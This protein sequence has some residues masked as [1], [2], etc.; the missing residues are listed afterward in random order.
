MESHTKSHLEAEKFIQATKAFNPY[1]NTPAT[2]EELAEALT[3]AEN[4]DALAANI[5][6]R[7]YYNGEGGKDADEQEAFIWFEK[8][9]A[10]NL[11][12]AI[13]NLVYLYYI[14]PSSKDLK[15]LNLEEFI[16]INHDIHIGFTLLQRLVTEFQY[17][18]AMFALQEGIIHHPEIAEQHGL[19]PDMRWQLLFDSAQAG[20]TP[21]M[22]VL[23]KHLMSKATKQGDPIAQRYSAAMQAEHKFM[24]RARMMARFDEVRE[25]AGQTP[26][27]KWAKTE[28]WRGELEI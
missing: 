26:T 23:S 27:N 7:A 15:N 10:A 19:F 1:G 24:L 18:P 5:V 28:E 16:A 9:A 14:P 25:K 17:A 13:F 11:P 12:Q 22:V 20:F 2:P 6:G 4:G 3:L 21:A 8:A